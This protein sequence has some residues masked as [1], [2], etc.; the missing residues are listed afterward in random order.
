LVATFGHELEFDDIP[1]QVVRAA[2][3]HTLDALGVGL[4][5][6]SLNLP[7][8]I[9]KVLPSLGS[10]EKST[11]LGFAQRVPPPSAALLNGMLI[12]S[13]EFDDTHIASVI[14][15]S[16][17][18]VPAAMAITES[19]GLSGQDFL[20]SV[21]IGWELLVRLGLAAPGLFQA[22]GFQTTAACG[23]FAAALIS[24]LLLGLDVEETVSAMGIA[25]SQCS[26]VFE[27]L[28]DGSTNKALYPGWAAH[29][30][31]IAGYL[32]RGGVT[33]PAT[34]LEG[35][36]G[37]YSIYARKA[38]VADRLRTFLD[39][40]G[41]M[42]YLPEAALKAYPCCHYIHSFLECLQN[43]IQDGL[44][45][46]EVDSIQCFVPVEEVP[47]ICEPWERKLHPASGYEAKFSLPYCLSLLLRDGEVNVSSFEGVFP[48]EEILAMAGKVTYTPQK[49]REFPKRFPGRLEVSMKS[50]KSLKASVSDVRGSPSRPLA[51]EEI[52]RKFEINALTRLTPKA[53]ADVAGVVDR[54]EETST[55]TLL[56]G[57]LRQI[58]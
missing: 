58:T 36:Y 57:A 53:A 38:S 12:H 14:H 32:A 40:L 39:E 37:L 44:L 31:I 8:Q 26:G 35:R 15:G 50:G 3:D 55:L 17:V 47:I 25:S 41:E 24:S 27:Y 54:L 28:S 5:A 18:I 13:L 56:S 46:E 49:I 1:S 52:R 11:I 33:G 9:E 23:P 19:E 30:G 21:V 45:A 4:A 6:S 2:K 20:R 7:Q 10:G 29:G 34:I 16:S 43:L 48:R 42:W 51:T 22:S